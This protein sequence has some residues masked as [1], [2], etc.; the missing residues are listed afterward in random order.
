MEKGS[1]RGRHVK[2]LDYVS[3]RFFAA[4]YTGYGKNY[5]CGASAL[6]IITGYNPNTIP[7]YHPSKHFSDD[8]MIRYMRQRAYKVIR[9]TQC[10]VSR[11]DNPV[12]LDHVLLISQLIRRNEATWCVCY[13]DACWH[14]FANYTV[15][16]FTY[17]DKPILSAYVIW[18][19]KYQV[20]DMGRSI[21]PPP[22]KVANNALTWGKLRGIDIVK[23]LENRD[24][25]R[26]S[27]L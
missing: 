8:I 4:L 23:S 10:L 15:D 6:A 7:K 19:T 16:A 3:P 21:P 20:I 2:L 1:Y 13:G 22:N 14:G 11:G 12:R 26:R 17:L 5:P 9:L 27:T 25:Q 18:H 24:N